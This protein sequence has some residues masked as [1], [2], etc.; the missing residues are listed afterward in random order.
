VEEKNFFE[1]VFQN[2]SLWSMTVEL[3]EPGFPLSWDVQFVNSE[4]SLARHSGKRIE[5]IV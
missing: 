5:T 1:G 3:T 4:K 2:D